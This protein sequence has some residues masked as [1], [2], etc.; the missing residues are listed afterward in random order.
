MDL[1]TIIGIIVGFILIVVSILLNADFEI[2]A[3]LNFAD[4]P[5]ILI[6][7]GGTVCSVMIAFPLQRIKQALKAVKRLFSP[8]DLDPSDA[9]TNIIT[10]AN[11]ARREGILALEETARNMEDQFLQ[12][13]IMLIV[14]GTDPELTRNILETEISYVD[15]RH[16]QVKAVW[17]IAGALS[18]AWGMIGT[19][20]G[21]VMMLQNMEDP[22]AIGPA[23]AI[24]LITTLYGS[25]LANFIFIPFSNKLKGLNSEEMLMKSVLI[26]GMLSIQAGENPRI[27][28]EKLKSFLSP[29][30]RNSGDDG[31]D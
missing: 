31:G 3:L 18:P 17:D 21:L 24:A 25:M 14:D 6:V 7:L 26:E 10:L 4:P 13:G 29:G 22:D 27:I 1:G 30:L 28:E 15:T 2:V 12:K 11:L 9:I 19:L 8:P 5:S 20:I 16:G 23:M